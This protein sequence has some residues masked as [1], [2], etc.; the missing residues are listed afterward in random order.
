MQHKPKKSRRVWYTL[1]TT[2]LLALGSLAGCSTETT[3]P[4]SAE[5]I[6]GTLTETALKGGEG[7]GEGAG[8]GE[9]AMNAA[10]TSADDVAYLTQLGLMRGHLWVGNELYQSDLVDMAATHM[11]HPKAELYSTL[12]EPFAIRGVDGFSSELETLATHVTDNAG[13][14]EV[15]AAYTKLTAAI[16][17]SERGAET[18]S[19][20]IIGEV[21]VALLRTAAEEY[22]IGVV[23]N[24]INNLHEYQ[25]ALGF[26][27]I[28][29]QW[30][31]S[32]AFL[33]ANAA[34]T[35][36]SIQAIISELDVMW[37]GLNPQKSV[38]QQAARLYGAAAR[39][40]IQILG[41]E[42]G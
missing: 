17:T 34:A 12:E 40:E 38:P 20:K 31:R 3:T 21:I 14:R 13:A 19:A 11:K 18:G 23:D 41:L 42:P 4:N 35:A 30:A 32:P 8:E 37:P 2:G 10:L 24:E 22:A 36:A 15:D 7:A 9:G 33:D 39:I 28:A 6:A 29:S 1:E 25:D 27:R 26:T 5:S 16:S